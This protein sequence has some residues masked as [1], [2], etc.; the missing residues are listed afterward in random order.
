MQNSK[1][2]QLDPEGEVLEDIKGELY[3][4]QAK[5]LK[6]GPELD[7]AADAAHKASESIGED[8]D[9]LFIAGLAD[10]QPTS[11]RPFE[12]LDELFA[13][14][15]REQR[16]VWERWPSTTDA[17]V[18]IA[19]VTAA[20]EKREQLETRIREKH[21]IPDGKPLSRNLNEAL[22]RASYFGTVVKGWRG[23]FF[24]GREFN[25]ANFRAAMGSR[26]F[27]FFIQK[28]AMNAE[29]FRIARVER[30]SGN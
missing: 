10:L 19:H 20:A 6:E 16:G 7:A 8:E 14:E 15:D 30:L 12:S 25:E 27:R 11:E 4:A 24:N 5:D 26:Q 21:K 22:W 9:D 3:E 23:S 1:E 18:L 29:R 17:E 28:N 13:V 2:P